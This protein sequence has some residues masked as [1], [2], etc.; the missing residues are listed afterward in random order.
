MV[1]I[2]QRQDN[3]EFAGMVESMDESLGRVR[4]KLTELGI[5]DNTIIIFFSDNGGMAGKM[6][7]DP[8]SSINKRKR[9]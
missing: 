4:A 5:A 1:K 9:T 6:P 7:G 8:I 3:I 2:S